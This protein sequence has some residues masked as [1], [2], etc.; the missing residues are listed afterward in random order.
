MDPTTVAT[1]SVVCA[2]TTYRLSWLTLLVYPMRA[3]VQ[4]IS[5]RM[6]LVT[7]RGLQELVR[8]RYG[9]RWGVVL[10][11]TVLAVNLVTLAADLEAGAALGMV[12]AVAVFWFIL[13]AAGGTAGA[14][15]SSIDTAQDAASSLQ[16]V[17]G[18]GAKY[19]F[20][21]GLLARD[22]LGDPL[23]GDRDRRLV[24]RRA[25]DVSGPAGAPPAAVARRCRAARP[26]Q[27]TAL[28]R[29]ADA[30]RAGSR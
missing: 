28:R 23:C 26:R 15:H 21:V 5:A 11:I 16:P 14:H 25:G 29:P 8:A 24:H 2:T 13:V 22:R 18:A 9:R 30:P 3:N 10:L 27:A 20:A 12:V 17:A 1:K 6:G 4:V 7:S 19:T